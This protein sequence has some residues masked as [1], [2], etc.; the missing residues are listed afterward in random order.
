M[1]VMTVSERTE[2]GGARDLLETAAILTHL[3]PEVRLIA[4]LTPGR[5]PVLEEGLR[6][7]LATGEGRWT[8][9][10]RTSVEVDPATET[11]GALAEVEGLISIETTTIEAI[12]GSHSQGTLGQGPHPG[13]IQDRWSLSLK[14][15]HRSTVLKLT[16]P[17]NRNQGMMMS[18]SPESRCVRMS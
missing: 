4:V 8:G 11:L 10:L 17:W 12:K 6:I 7:D 18:P 15:I 1:P 5:D 16:I 2:I 3:V 13:T 14:N 9:G